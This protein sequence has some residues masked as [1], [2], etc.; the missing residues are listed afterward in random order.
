MRAIALI[1]VGCALALPVHGD[2]AGGMA[3]EHGDMAGMTASPL[4]SPGNDAFGAIQE[5][6][7]TLMADPNTDWSRIDLEPLREHLVDMQNFT[8]N[9]DVTQAPIE[10]GF[11]AK[12]RPT[13]PAAAGS[14]ARAFAA[15]PAFLKQETGWDMRV[16]RQGDTYLV[17]VTTANP[18]E[19]AKIRGLGYIGIM[20]MGAHHQRHHWMMIHRVDP[21][22]TSH[23]Q[24]TP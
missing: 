8:V 7:Q 24:G 18:K 11:E 4:T 5:V 22:H 9:V 19:V 23:R 3:H 20:A 6:V 12:V 21:H 14:L 2:P 13:T 17:R 10:N 1:T 16:A 15:H